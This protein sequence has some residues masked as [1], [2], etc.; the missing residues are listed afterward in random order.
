MPRG[1]KRFGLG[2]FVVALSL[3]VSGCG[4]SGG[5]TAGENGGG[6]QPPSTAA[7]GEAIDWSTVKADIRFV[8][9][10][11]SEAEKELA[12]QF[13]ARMKEKYPNVNIEY[14]YLSWADMEKKLSVMLN[15]GDVPDL[16]QTQDVTNLVRLNG[17]ED[18]TPYFEQEGE[19]LKKDD[20]LPG[21]MEYAQEDGK[22]YAV[23]NLANSFTLIVNEQMLN[24]AGM[25]LEDL[26]TWEDVEKAAKAMTKD[27]KYGF[28]YPLGIARFSFRVP[29]TAAYS[30]DLLLSD[31]S[32]ESKSKYMETLQHFKN[33]EPYQP[34][35][36]LTWGYPE[37]FRAYSNGEVGM[38]AAGTFFT[39][40]VYSINPDIVNV[41]RTIAYP[42]GPS[43]TVAKAPVSNVG[44]AMFKDSKNKEVAWRLIQEWSSQ[45]FNSTA[46]SVVNVTAIKSTS[47]DEIIK[48]SE[49]IYPKAIEGHKTMLNDFSKLLD[50]S[51]VPM[52]KIPGQ[53]EME[54]VVQEQMAKL[55]NDKVTVEEAYAA[56]K[57][58]IDKI[59]AKLE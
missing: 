15:S 24:E 35:A 50:E 33:L 59:K 36:H 11:T 29:F 57:D 25:K 5:N 45:E 38:I 31:T 4:A 13:K 8:Y 42:K 3:L 54:V 7:S 58:G 2:T 14:M 32:D 9:P 30:N 52:D 49:K 46:A 41:S 17:L 53:S 23:P 34:K 26:Q 51:G 21:T 44:I 47:L 20:F 28:G 1:K 37:M 10:G 43:G 56:I 39:A 12:E 18:L 19:Q 48:K 55:L 40:N 22:L 6:S 27:G 16:T